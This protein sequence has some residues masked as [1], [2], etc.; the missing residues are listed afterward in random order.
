MA[1]RRLWFGYS[2]KQG[3][4]IFRANFSKKFYAITI[5][6]WKIL[7]LPGKYTVSSILKDYHD[8]KNEQYGIES[9]LNE[10]INDLL[11]YFNSMLGS[12]LLYKFERLQ[13]TEV[14]AV[15]IKIF[16]FNEKN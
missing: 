8:Q 1:H 5:N 12:Q 7:E 16:Y 6:F 15:L 9:I 2:S 14:L 4:T 11:E 3:K 13:Y 10:I